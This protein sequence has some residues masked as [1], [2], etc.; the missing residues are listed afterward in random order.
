V[1]LNDDTCVSKSYPEFFN[2][3]RHLGAQA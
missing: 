1:T 3:L 2:H